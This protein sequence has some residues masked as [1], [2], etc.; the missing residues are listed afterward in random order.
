MKQVLR[1]TALTGVVAILLAF[2]LVQN[3]KYFE[4]SKNIEIFTNVYKELNTWYVDDLDPAT[5]MRHGID[6]MVG[7][8]DPFTNYFSESQIEGY[9]Q[10]EGQYDGIGAKI[11]EIDGHPTIVEPY[12]KSPAAT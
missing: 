8:L 11:L 6:A 7:S 3:G 9:R 10:S 5:L 2:T 1:I 12:A 4:I